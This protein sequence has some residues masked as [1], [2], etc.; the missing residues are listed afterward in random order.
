M[1]AQLKLGDTWS[2]R[3]VG[4]EITLGFTVGTI[5]SSLSPAS[6]S[7][8]AWGN[9]FSLFWA[10]ICPITQSGLGLVAQKA[11][12][13]S[14]FRGRRAVDPSQSLEEGWLLEV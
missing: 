4:G 5:V 3:A 1:E 6:N 7:A 12:S 9:L 10:S 14:L 11:C 8:R 13:V 2:P